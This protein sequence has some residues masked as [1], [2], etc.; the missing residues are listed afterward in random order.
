MRAAVPPGMPRRGPQP[1]RPERLK[2][3][4]DPSKTSR[5]WHSLHR[6]GL[7]EMEQ[8]AGLC[9]WRELVAS[10]KATDT[11][12]QHVEEN[13]APSSPVYSSL[14]L[15]AC[16]RHQCPPVTERTI[17]S[18]ATVSGMVTPLRRAVERYDN[19]CR[20]ARRSTARSN[21]S[22]HLAKDAKAYWLPRALAPVY[23]PSAQP[24]P[25]LPS[26]CC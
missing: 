14:A 1:H 4:E 5:Q 18:T 20:V 22:A 8:C 2:F 10:A 21:C 19:A 3:G 23:S 6:Q 26:G 17:S 16:K 7:P 25:N 9:Q 12:K 15:N 24:L 13:K 11:Q